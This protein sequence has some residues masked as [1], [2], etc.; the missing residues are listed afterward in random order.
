MIQQ[1]QASK[2]VIKKQCILRY[3]NVQESPSNG[4]YVTAFPPLLSNG[5]PKDNEKQCGYKKTKTFSSIVMELQ[6]LMGRLSQIPISLWYFVRLVRCTF[7]QKPQRFQAPSVVDASG[8][9]AVVTGGEYM[10]GCTA[11]YDLVLSGQTACT[12]QILYA[13][14]NAGIGLETVRHLAA[15]GL[16]VI[17]GCRDTNKGEK[18][19]Q[20]L[21]QEVKG[22]LV[23]LQADSLLAGNGL[24]TLL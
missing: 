6:K 15:S 7:F 4:V 8:K 23:F 13:T 5:T 12:D 9:I 20:L 24:R 16:K 18:A 11:P 22:K 2:V 3:C 21:E 14:G 10:N 19:V 17:V 1:S